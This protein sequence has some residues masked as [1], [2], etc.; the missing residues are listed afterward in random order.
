VRLFDSIS[1]KW[2]N[3]QKNLFPYLE[4]ELGT[5]SEKQR[6]LVM[7]LEMLDIERFVS[8]QYFRG[9]PEKDRR[10]IVR[11]FFAKAGYNMSTTRYLIDRLRSD[12]TLRRLC[13]WERRCE[14][15]SES[16][17]S[18]A[19]GEFT[20]SLLLFL[21][22]GKLITD[23]MYN[24]LIGHISRDSTD[25]AA[26]EK[27]VKKEDSGEDK[28]KRK[29]GRPRK[30]E[31]R[32]KEPKRL[33]RQ[34][35]MTFDEMIEDLPRVCDIGSK[36][37]SKGNVKH[38]VGYKLHLDIAD[39]QIPISYILSSA[40]LH[41][42]QV[43]LPLMEM[44]KGRVTNLYDL[45]DSAYDSK[46][47]RDYSRSLGHVPIIDINPRR[48]KELKEELN[49]EARRLKAI[50]F[51]LPEARRYK[52]RSS[53]ERVNG[54]LKD[55]FGGRMVRVRGNAKVMTHLMFGIIFLT[56]DQMMRLLM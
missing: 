46:I 14:V 1:G 35:T 54:R 4:E 17:F 51:K 3:F 31:E 30:G 33:E 48:D 18:R 39:G 21:L 47:I 42:S 7:T 24:Q 52:E 53:V 19:F 9:R 49:T 38:W 5:L 13:G 40:S 37:D 44:T 28:P 8:V 26:R 56:V 32:V 12:P 15:P 50:N 11:A 45:M 55:E 41:D 27:P 29:R 16:T 20:N 34:L 23:N 6:K 22:H 43:A 2:K 36:K 25:I 10:A